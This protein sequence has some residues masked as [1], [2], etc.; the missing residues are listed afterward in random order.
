MRSQEE[1]SIY[2]RWRNED[3]AHENAM[4]EDQMRADQ[5]MEAAQREAMLDAEITAFLSENCASKDA[6]CDTEYYCTP[7]GQFAC[8]KCSA[9]APA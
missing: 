1:E 8:K 3:V 6:D 9:V 7:D 5:A 2:S 4:I